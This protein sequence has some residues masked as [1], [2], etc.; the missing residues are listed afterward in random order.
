MRR[1]VLMTYCKEGKEGFNWFESVEEMKQYMQD[2]N[3]ETDD[4]L[5]TIVVKDFE[6]IQI[7]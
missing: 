5:D 7:D 4:L 6:N 1:N 3:I 2:N